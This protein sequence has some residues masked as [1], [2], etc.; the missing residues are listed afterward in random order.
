MVLIF[1][2]LIIFFPIFPRVFTLLFV[3][4]PTVFV[5][6]GICS[7]LSVFVFSLPS[8]RIEWVAD[9]GLCHSSC[10]SF[11]CT[12]LCTLLCS[13]RQRFTFVVVS[14][15][16]AV[17]VSCPLPSLSFGHRPFPYLFVVP[18]S[19]LQFLFTICTQ[20]T[21]HR[22]H[23]YIECTFRSSFDILGSVHSYQFCV[24]FFFAK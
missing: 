7:L 16:C 21:F 23:L 13:S 20:K 5:M 15:F 14:S 11:D 12:L 19:F 6:F 17:F 4:L 22:L 8:I 9:F 3:F 24:L 1:I 18:S 2:L 10:A